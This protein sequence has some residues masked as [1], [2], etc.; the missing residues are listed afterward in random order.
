MD[1]KHSV[2]RG[3]HCIFINYTVIHP[4]GAEGC[5]GGGGG[6]EHPETIQLL[7]SSFSLRHVFLRCVQYNISQ[8]PQLASFSGT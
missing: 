4:N 8:V 3:L 6:R 2:I 7:T 5:G 1:P